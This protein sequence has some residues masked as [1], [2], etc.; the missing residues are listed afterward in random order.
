DDEAEEELYHT[1]NRRVDILKRLAAE[2]EKLN[3]LILDDYAKSLSKY[4]ESPTKL[5]LHNIKTE[6]MKPYA[7]P[8]RIFEIPT[9]EQLFEMETG[10]T[11]ET[12]F[13]GLIVAAEI[14]RVEER[15][16]KCRLTEHQLD[17]TITIGNLVDYRITSQDIQSKYAVGQLLKAKII[18]I[19]KKKFT[20]AL[21]TRP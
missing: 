2:P 6:L 15:A 9:A 18:N 13:A 7:D 19:D 21:S 17:G 20:V 3:D 4:Y 10:E 14:T 1:N 8:R 12:L 5:I 16:L 11:D